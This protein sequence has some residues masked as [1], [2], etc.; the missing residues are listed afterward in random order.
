[1]AEEQI[2]LAAQDVFVLLDV[3]IPPS[4][5]TKKKKWVEDSESKNDI[6]GKQTLADKE[7]QSNVS[8]F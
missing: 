1:M 6:Y 5:S 8:I 4:L 3:P 2:N 7:L